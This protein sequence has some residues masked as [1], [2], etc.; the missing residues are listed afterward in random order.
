VK[1]PNKF[2]KLFSINQ[3]ALQTNVLAI[4]AEATRAGEEGRGFAVVAEEVGHL[5]AKS[6]LLKKL[7]RLLKTFK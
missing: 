5:A 2:L 4:N 1:I 6:P 3:I 7:N